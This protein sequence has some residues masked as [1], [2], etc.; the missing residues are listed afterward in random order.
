MSS[1]IQMLHLPINAT[2]TDWDGWKKLWFEKVDMHN[3]GIQSSSYDAEKSND[4][5]L[6][7]TTEI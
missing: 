4:L 2:Q 7:V 6:Y 5:S 1:A 3:E